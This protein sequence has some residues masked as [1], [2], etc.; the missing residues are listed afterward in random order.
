MKK[1]INCSFKGAAKHGSHLIESAPEQGRLTVDYESGSTTATVRI[2]AGSARHAWLVIAEVQ[3]DE[4]VD[5]LEHIATRCLNCE[6]PIR[7]INNNPA[8]R[9][10]WIH[11]DGFITCGGHGPVGAFATPK[12]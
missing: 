11:F 6:R 9:Y 3:Y 1:T 12:L 5:V 10:E 4:L 7:R 8:E 2:K